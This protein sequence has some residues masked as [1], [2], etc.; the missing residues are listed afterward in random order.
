M[1]LPISIIG[2]FAGMYLCGFSINNLT[3]LALTLS[4][5][6]VVDDAIVMLENIVRYIEGGMRPLQAALKGSKEIGFT[7]ISIT[8]SL[9]AVFI[10]VLFMGGI[11]GRLFNEF[12]VTISLAILISGLRVSD[13][14]A[15]ALLALVAPARSR[16]SP[17]VSTGHR[18]RFSRGCSQAIVARS[19]GVAPATADATGDA[20]D[21][22]RDDLGFRRDPKGFF[23]NE[24]TGLLF[25]T[26][27]G[28][29]DISF[30]AMVERQK[31][32]AEIMQADPNV[33]LANSIA[34]SV[35][36][37]QLRTHSR[38]TKAA[39]RSASSRRNRCKTSCAASSPPFP[40][41]GPTSNSF[42]TSRSAGDWPPPVPVHAAGHRPSGTVR[43]GAET[44]SAHS[45]ASG[46]ARRDSDLR[47]SSRQAAVDIDRDAAA[48]LGVTIEQVRSTL[49][50]AFGG[51]EVSTIFTPTNDYRVILEVAPENKRGSVGAFA[52]LRPQRFRD[53]GAAG[54]DRRV[55]LEAAP[56]SIVASG[57]AAGGDDFVQSRARHLVGRGGGEHPAGA[58]GDRHSRLD[59][60]RL[61]GH[62]RG[63]PGRQR[64][65][66]WC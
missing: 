13:A 9:V 44:R 39:R 35:R 24:D 61:P 16:P 14:D 37:R 26:T 38:A 66:S 63:I 50:S 25:I 8:V 4:V 60:D 53:S 5:G 29:Q 55:R 64:A 42:R 2:T 40:A 51:R 17:A 10:P 22:R 19:I 48:R 47:S 6:F 18:R 52:A 23:P 12:A 32:V 15:D 57:T 59:P 56:L 20:R 43:D 58:A 27:E 65:I 3:L 1:A 30:E 41:S 33:T 21:V 49:Y 62:R 34:A 45:S 11:V 46:H 28:A 54:R 36:R 31:L 7:I